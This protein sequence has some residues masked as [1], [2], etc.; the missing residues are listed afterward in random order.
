MLDINKLAA[1]QAVWLSEEL[2]GLQRSRTLMCSF[3]KDLDT[4]ESMFDVKEPYFNFTKEM[5]GV[6]FTEERASRER[7]IKVY[8]EPW[9]PGNVIAVKGDKGQ[10]A[11]LL[12]KPCFLFDDKEDN[13]ATLR[14][15]QSQYKLDGIVVRIGRKRRFGVEQGFDSTQDPSAWLGIAADFVRNYGH[16]VEH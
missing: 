8:R 6:I 4:R 14:L 2:I 7:R 13:I 10:A 5:D 12:N 1:R 11:A 3:S 15:R 16:K 9:M